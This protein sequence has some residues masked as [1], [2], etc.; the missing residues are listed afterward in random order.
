M[1]EA[2]RQGHQC[3]AREP[4]SKRSG[5]NCAPRKVEQLERVLFGLSGGFGGDPC[6]ARIQQRWPF[7]GEVLEGTDW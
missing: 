3:C 6:R 4:P 1:V 2:V 5:L 7:R